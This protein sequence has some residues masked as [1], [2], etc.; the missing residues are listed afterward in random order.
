MIFEIVISLFVAFGL[1][2]FCS[3]VAGS[4]EDEEFEQYLRDEDERK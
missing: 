1:Y 3:V 2:C 4:D